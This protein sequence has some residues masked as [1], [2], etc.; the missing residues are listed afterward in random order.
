[1]QI[2]EKLTEKAHWQKELDTVV[3]ELK[4]MLIKTSLEK[5]TLQIKNAQEFENVETLE[6]LNRRFR[7]LSLK[8]KNL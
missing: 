2:D 3:H 6:V 7:D 5:L 4:K 1:M 8:L